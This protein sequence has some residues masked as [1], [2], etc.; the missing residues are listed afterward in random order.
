MTPLFLNGVTKPW[1]YELKGGLNSV[2]R[3]PTNDFRVSDPSVSSFHCELE[4]TPES[5]T[6]RDLGSTNGTYID[7]QRIQESVLSPGQIL[8][9]GSA[10]VRLEEQAIRIVIPSAPVEQAEPRRAALEHGSLA[11]I[12]HP[13]VAATLKC[14]H[15]Q[16]LFCGDCVRVLRRTGG[17]TMIFCPACSGSCESLGVVAQGPKRKKKNLLGR[18][19]QTIRLRF[20]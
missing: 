18:L 14:S 1:S 5:V 7:G 8:K 4:V 3:N 16:Q 15:C 10:D 12:N 13:E 11:C 6:V 19:T 2:G 20:K 9:L 17:K